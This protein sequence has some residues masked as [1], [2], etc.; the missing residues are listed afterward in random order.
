MNANWPTAYILLEPVVCSE[1]LWQ[2]WRVRS[3]WCPTQ[4][5]WSVE[6]SMEYPSSSFT[7]P[8]RHPLM[9]H[10][11]DWGVTGHRTATVNDLDS[12]FTRLS[13]PNLWQNNSIIWRGKEMG[14]TVWLGG[15]AVYEYP[16]DFKFCDS[17]TQGQ[18]ESAVCHFWTPSQSSL[19]T[20]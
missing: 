12:C 6:V 5:W 17:T 7:C 18:M 13:S 16:Q 4:M 1:R 3:G 14:R 10:D 8:S 11:S 2:E 15:R 9:G 20:L 19:P